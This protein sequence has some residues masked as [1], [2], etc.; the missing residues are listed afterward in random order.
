[1]ILAWLADGSFCNPSW[2][3]ALARFLRRN[4]QSLA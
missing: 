1:M 2:V 3:Q 4:Q